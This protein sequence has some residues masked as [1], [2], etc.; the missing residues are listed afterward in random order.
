[1]KILD[2]MFNPQDIKQETVFLRMALGKIPILL[3]NK[4]ISNENYFNFYFKEEKM[5]N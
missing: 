2:E 1:M 5:H 4:E 3:S